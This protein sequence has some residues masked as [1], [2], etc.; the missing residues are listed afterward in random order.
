MEAE[1][2]KE[3]KGIRAFNLRNN[4]T[5]ILIKTDVNN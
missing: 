5:S 1:G 2:V 4:T 3:E